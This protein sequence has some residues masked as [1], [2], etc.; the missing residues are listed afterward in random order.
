[1]VKSFQNY[2]N[3]NEDVATE[4]VTLNQ[5]EADAMK[6]VNDAQIKLTEIRE[7]IKAAIVK[8]EEEKKL[9]AAQAPTVV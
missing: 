1:M 5:Q 2:F 7:K 4:L 9:V 8:Q 6:V 3:V